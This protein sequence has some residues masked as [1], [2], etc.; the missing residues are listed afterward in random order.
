MKSSDLEQDRNQRHARWDAA[1]AAAGLRTYRKL[2]S[3][4]GLQESYVA[5]LHYSGGCLDPRGMLRIRVSRFR[6]RA[7]IKAE[8]FEGW[9]DAPSKVTRRFLIAT[10]WQCIIEWV[11]AAGFWQLPSSHSPSSAGFGG[12][13]WTVEGF[14]DGRFH[15]V[16]RTSWSVLEGVGAE[17]F[18]L[19][20]SMTQLA[21]L[22][23][24]DKTEN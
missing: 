7:T 21:G 19:G 8:V 24:F 4:T 9:E 5:Q 22:D 12:E 15:F 17:V 20:R 23:L 3:R 14:R 2:A 16:G 1:K 11:D 18:R 13:R 6:V 10:E